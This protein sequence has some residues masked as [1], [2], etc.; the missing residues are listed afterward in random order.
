MEAL[1]FV[2]E[3]DE[4][5]FEIVGDDGWGVYVFRYFAGQNT[6]DYLQDN[7]QMAHRCAEAEWGVPVSAWRPAL[8]GEKPLWKKP[9]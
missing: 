2:A 8:A 9:N 1:L 6:H 4:E 5:R 7:V 3:R